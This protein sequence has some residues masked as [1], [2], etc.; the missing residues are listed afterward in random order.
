MCHLLSMYDRRDKNINSQ[1][2]GSTKYISNTRGGV[3]Q[4]KIYCNQIMI[5]IY[6]EYV[7]EYLINDERRRET[8]NYNYQL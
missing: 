2:N 7:L 3:M 6:L 4:N 1:I 8:D 5:N